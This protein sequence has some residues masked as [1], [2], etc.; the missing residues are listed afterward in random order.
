MDGAVPPALTWLIRHGQSASNAGLPTTG[1][2]DVPLTEFGLAQ[3]RELAQRFERAPDLLILSP[4]LRA[5]ATAGP[6]LERW[7]DTQCETWPIQELTYLSPS[8]C[9]G[10]TSTTRR[11]W[12]DEY[13]R[14]C[15]PD[16]CDA[17]DAESFSAFLGRLRDFH[18]RL[19]ALDAGFVVAVGHGQFF[20]AYLIA[21]EQGF[22]TSP[23]WMRDYRRKETAQPMVNCEVIQLVAAQLQGERQHGAELANEAVVAARGG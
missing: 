7:P 5:S 10:T 8:R 9:V 13:W 16:Y 2:D 11:P 4:F 18:R 6:I 22:D 3:A 21:L 12:I 17:A 19:L 1:H 15:D 20:R 14:R 23:Q